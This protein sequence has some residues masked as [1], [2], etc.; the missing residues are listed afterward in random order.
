M[1]A[2]NCGQ[3]VA[4]YD[5]TKS[6]KMREEAMPLMIWLFFK[7]ILPIFKL[8]L[9]FYQPSKQSYIQDVKD[10]PILGC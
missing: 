7:N 3:N 6:S 9:S 4:D 5:S 2:K 8:N 1:M 10:K